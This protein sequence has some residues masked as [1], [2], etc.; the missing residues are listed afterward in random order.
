MSLGGYRPGAGRKKGQR[1][2]Q[3][4]KLKD[5]LVAEIMREKAPIIKA[6]VR[7]AKEGDIIAIREVLERTIGKVK[8]T[9]EFST[10]EPLNIIL[11]KA[12]EKIYGKDKP[13]SD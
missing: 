11:L 13:N 6:L 10:G 3:S 5:F 7:K 1:T 9:M 8:E 12:I 4:E 2:I